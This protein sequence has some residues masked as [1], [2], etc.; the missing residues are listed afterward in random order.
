MTRARDLQLLEEGS[1]A[2]GTALTPEQTGRL[3]GYLDLLYVWNRT[4]GLTTIPPGDAVRL[5]VLD[6]LSVLPSI[7][8]GPCLD[9]GTGAGLPGIVLA[10][11]R[12]DVLVEL[13]ES[14]RKKCSFLLEAV[15]RL[16]LRNVRVLQTDADALPEDRKFPTVV[17]RA[18]R[19]PLEFLRT[20]VRFVAPDGRI[21]L[22]TANATDTDLRELAG[23]SGLTLQR[24]R[25]LSLPAGDEPRAVATF[26]LDVGHVSRET[27][28]APVPGTD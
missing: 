21:L 22:M 27:W 25:R 1:A 23:N 10:I 14:N 24:C 6:S 9:L 28:G 13:V 16:G 8:D 11:A 7:V 15:R 19:Q 5:H 3:L 20:A 18:F 12:P 4:A 17:S 2:L 26:V